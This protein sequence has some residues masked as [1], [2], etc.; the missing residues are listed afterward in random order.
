M[1]VLVTFSDRRWFFRWDYLMEGNS[2]YRSLNPMVAYEKGLITWSKWV[3]LNLDP[4]TTRIV[5]RSMSP[6]H[7]RYVTNKLNHKHRNQPQIIHNTHKTRHGPTA[8][9]CSCNSHTKKCGWPTA[10]VRWW[11]RYSRP[12]RLYI[13]EYFKNR[14]TMTVTVTCLCPCIVIWNS[15]TLCVQGERL[16]VLQPE[17]TARVRQPP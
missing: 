9:N 10:R 12:Q 4:R 16:E 8:H 14:Y 7:N 3:D 11:L 15:V 1:L 13:T 6:R 5:F 2:A 17:G